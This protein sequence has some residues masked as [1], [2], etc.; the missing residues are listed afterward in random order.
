MEYYQNG[1][2]GSSSLRS[3]RHSKGIRT[4]KGPLTNAAEARMISKF[5]ATGCLDDRSRSGR[6][7]TR[8]NADETVQEEMVAVSSMRGEVSARAVERR[9][10]IPYTTLWLALRP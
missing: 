8:R 4:G 3:Y 7:S 6:S 10:G 9:T 5:E 1:E 2:C